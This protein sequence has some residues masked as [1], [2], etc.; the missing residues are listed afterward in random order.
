VVATLIW[1]TCVAVSWSAS[2]GPVA[3]YHVE[4]D[5]IVQDVS[6]ERAVAC[7][8]DTYTPMIVRVQGFDAAGIVG[9]WS[10]PL[11]LERIHN[12][13]SSGDGV[14]GYAD[15][16]RLQSHFGIRHHPSGIAERPR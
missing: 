16:G 15:F 10:D 1:L 4:V 12:F 6:T 14:V 3:G 9:P 11:T 7:V 2:V 13:D 5:G 8:P